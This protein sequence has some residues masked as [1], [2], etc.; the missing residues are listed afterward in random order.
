MK[1]VEKKLIKYFSGV[2][3]QKERD[4]IDFLRKNSKEFETIYTDYKNIW[5]LSSNV[6]SDSPKPNK[7]KVWDSISSSVNS[8]NPRYYSVKAFVR[9]ISI[10]AIFALF[11]GVSLT[12]YITDNKDIKYT[13]ITSPRGQ[14]TQA[15]LPDGTKVWLN[16]ESTLTFANNFS[17][18]NRS[19]KLEGEAYF[20]VKKS[21]TQNFKVYFGD[22]YVK[23]LGTKFNVKACKEDDLFEISLLEGKVAVER[24][25]DDALLVNLMP[26]QKV[27]LNKDNNIVD[28]ITYCKAADEAL[29][30][31][32]KLKLDNESILTALNKMEKWYGVNIEAE[33]IPADLRLWLTIKTETLTE[34]LAILNKIRPIDYKLN[35]EEVTIK[36]K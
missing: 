20:D 2:S 14:K 19:V 33:N 21:L 35:G 9:A 13:T 8:K 28:R 1:E 18:K 5:E 29:W 27:S 12:L 6:L 22:F 25:F 34:V 3:S 36:Y 32:G 4:E 31:Y 16:S 7:S 26:N 10:A 24:S 17:S 11:F 30:H 15:I 23:V